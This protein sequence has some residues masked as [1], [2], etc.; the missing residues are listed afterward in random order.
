MLQS[1]RE[2]AQGWIA[3]VIVGLISIPFALWGINSY[4]DNAGDVSVAEVNGEAIPLSQYQNALQNYRQ[5]L[6]SML[7]D[8]IDLEMM[9]S[10]SIKED[11]INALIEQSLLDQTSQEAGLRVTDTQVAGMI[12]SLD[13]FKGEDGKFSKAIYDRR[14]LQSG[15]SPTVFEQQLRADMV[16]D[17]LRQGIADSAFVTKVDQESIAKLVSQQRD[18]LYTTILAEDFESDVTIS[19]EQIKKQ[20]DDNNAAYM[21]EEQV[22]LAY[23][24]L[25][26]ENIGKQI[27]FTDDDLETYYNNNID[28]YTTEERR[29]AHHVL[30]VVPPDA[31][32]EELAEAKASAQKL[33]E[34]MQT[35][36]DVD[37]IPQEHAELL[38]EKDEVSKSGGISKGVMD[39]EFDEALFS[40]EVGTVHEPVRS[41]SGFHI[42][43]LAEIQPENTS[44]FEESKEQVEAAYRKENAEKLFFEKADELHNLVY[45]HPDTLDVAA[46]A[47][48]MTVH[49]SDF[50]SRTTAKDV[51]ADPKVITAAF[52]EE[53]LAGTNGE[54]VELADTHLVVV[55]LIE[56]KLPAL[57]PLEEVSGT[58]KT[59][60]LNLETKQKAADK[61]QAILTKLKAG[62]DA[63]TVAKE[64]GIEWHKVE[65]VTRDDPSVKRAI[66]RNV[67][68]LGRP[69]ADNPLYSGM[70]VGRYD[71]S[72]VGVTAVNDV[73]EFSDE[74]KTNVSKTL[75]QLEESRTSNAWQDFITV[76][77]SNADIQRNNS[78]IQQ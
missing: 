21:T 22:K 63:D 10:E 53:V 34:L 52:S 71:F 67:F 1:I 12:H 28:N 75:D 16:Q 6:Q 42:I 31:K 56:H 73:E 54:P 47:L 48:G 5:R 69:E 46:D 58:I 23:L 19:D 37:L 11:V 68:K 20:Y 17:Q 64:F 35:G 13:A 45:E 24:D 33:Y 26:L 3:W 76:L 7:G 18:I 66:L 50:F 40:M 36:I 74:V 4:F 60:L 43:K 38:G 51:L 70:S 39:V 62:T 72:V 27:E 57:K 77:K 44:T 8:D 55:R 25:S 78:A 59:N 29:V 30:V 15:N 2:R 14:L 9:G 65:G 61:G 49:E 41:K 32:D